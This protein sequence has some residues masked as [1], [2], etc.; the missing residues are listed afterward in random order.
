MT[1]GWP[2]VARDICPVHDRYSIEDDRDKI[3]VSANFLPVP[4]PHRLEMTAFSRHTLIYRS[5]DLGGLELGIFF[6]AIIQDLNFKSV[7]GRIPRQGS[8]NPHTI[9]STGRQLE[10][11]L[12]NKVSVFLGRIDFCSLTFLGLTYQHPFNRL[13]RKSVV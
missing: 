9:I 12:K 11:E 6:C 13:D 1:L 8:P 5:M 3:S 7:L 10:F 2:F 4:L